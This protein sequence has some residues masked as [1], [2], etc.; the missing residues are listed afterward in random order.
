KTASKKLA[1]KALQ[2]VATSCWF[3]HRTSSHFRD[4]CRDID[5][6]DDC[7]FLIFPP[8]G[9]EGKPEGKGVLDSIS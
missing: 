6:R 7:Y 8:G 5:S 3:I 4:C 9:E 2:G 1:K